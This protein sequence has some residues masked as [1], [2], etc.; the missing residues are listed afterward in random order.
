MT[1]VTGPT[2]T[3]LTVNCTPNAM[4]ALT[5]AA[6]RTGDGRTDTVNRALQIYAALVA[7]EPGGSF[8]Y[9]VRPGVRRRVRVSE[10]VAR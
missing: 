5:E 2:L 10:A 8:T 3:K 6:G 9:E 7:T 4:A 1:D